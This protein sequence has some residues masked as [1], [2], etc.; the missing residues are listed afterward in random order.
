[1]ATPYEAWNSWDGWFWTEKFGWVWEPGESLKGPG[2]VGEG[3]APGGSAAAF[4]ASGGIAS[5]A[6]PASSSAGSSASPPKQAAVA[7]SSAPKRKIQLQPKAPLKPKPKV[8]A[9]VRGMSQADLLQ[10]VERMTGELQEVRTELAAARIA[11]DTLRELV[12]TLTQDMALIS[13]SNDEE[14]DAKLA[15]LREQWVMLVQQERERL[16]HL[17]RRVPWDPDPIEEDL[18]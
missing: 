16:E 7:P 12:N 18:Q 13:R 10:L 5:A 11:N 17:R 3:S 9:S 14:K 4:T 15:N 8:K 2:S 1:M 6:M